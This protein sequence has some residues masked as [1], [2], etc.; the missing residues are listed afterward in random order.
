MTASR[1]PGGAPARSGRRFR[2]YDVIVLA[3]AVAAIAPIARLVELPSFVDRITVTNPTVYDIGIEVTGNDDDGWT[4]VGTARRSTTST[5]G[6]IVDQGEVWIFR[7][8]AQGEDGGSL[9]VSRQQ[10]EGDGWRL[11]IP[12]E[13]RRALAKRGAPPPP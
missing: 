11:A 8:S 4:A 6:E 13:V 5:F 10:F 3:L 2:I 1:R 12:D 7:F 9:R